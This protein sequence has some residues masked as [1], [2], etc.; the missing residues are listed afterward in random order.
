MSNPG[1]V[2]QLR[3][4]HQDA[5]LPPPD[6][7]WIHRLTTG[8]QLDLNFWRRLTRT[9]IDLTNRLTTNQRERDELVSLIERVELA[10]T[11]LA[12]GA[13]PDVV[14]QHLSLRPDQMDAILADEPVQWQPPVAKAH[15]IRV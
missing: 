3:R 6:D 15:C 13:V 11:L 8:S 12:N 7:A 4:A 10:E 9:Y 2:A 1:I 5:G 14:A